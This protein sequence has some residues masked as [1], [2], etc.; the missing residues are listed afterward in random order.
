MDQLSSAPTIQEAPAEMAGVNL[1]TLTN[2]NA[3]VVKIFN[4]GG[5]IQSISFPDRQ[6]HSDAVTLG[7]STLADYETY[8]PAAYTGNTTEAGVYFGA[9]IGRYANRIARGELTLGGAKCQVPVN[10]GVNALHGG[11]VGFDRKVWTPATSSGPGTVSLRLTYVSMA[12]EMGFPGTLTTTATYTLD[13]EN[14]LTLTFHATTTAE[15][16][17]NLTN[18]TYWNLAGEFSGSVYDQML[19]INANGFTP[20]DSTLI[21]TGVIEPVAATP[22]DFTTPTPIGQNIDSGSQFTDADTQQLLICKGYD[23]NWVLNQ[24]SP[25]SLVLAARA[26]DPSS[27]RE[28]TVYTTQPGLHF[29][30]GNLSA[31]TLVGSSGHRQSDGFALETQ[32]FPNSPNQPNFPST[33]LRPGQSYSQTSVYQLSNTWRPRRSRP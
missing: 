4:Y 23:L 32:H 13:N 33:V 12:G 27:G 19:Y 11:T 22:F 17:V 7:F 6:G 31:A 20:V 5:I 25:S 8:S 26:W 2:C 24:T 14:R 10:N 1:Y 28:L 21:P 15:T 18:H 30:S 9:L 16:V 29:Y 3:M